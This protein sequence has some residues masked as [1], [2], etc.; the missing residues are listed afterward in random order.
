MFPAPPR[1]GNDDHADPAAFW[2]ARLNGGGPTSAEDEAGFRR[3][4]DE[5]SENPRA[6]R[7]CQ[8]TWRLLELDAAEPEVLALRSAALGPED[9]RFNRRRALFG[10]TGGAVAAACGGLW[11]MTSASAAR[12]L[13]S[14]R[15]GQ[16]LTAPLPDGSEVTL[17]PMT[18]LRLD[19]GQGRRA[20]VLETGQAY[21]N[22]LP[23]AAQPFSLRVGERVLTTEQGRFQLTYLNDRPDILVEQGQLSLADRGG[24]GAVVRLETG[25]RVDVRN[26]RLEKA[27]ADVEVETAWRL[28]R[29]VVRD[30]P[31]REVVAAFN[32]Y[33][34]DR[35]AIED[36]AAGDKRISGSFRYDGGREFALALATG[37]DLSVKRAPD[38]VWRIRTPDE[39][40]T[41]R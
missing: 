35:L 4:L 25:Q 23:D 34:A 40:T 5:D 27:A 38:G 19:Y 39:T 7:S 26:G 32:H 3:W 13:I 14:T 16:R 12:A 22:I 29:L 37:F 21:F 18:R 20:V 28:G 36:Q 30:R 15:A 33:S 11:L 10:L 8:Q 24:E 17:A 9:R 41:L 31:L 1:P 6:Y 2:F